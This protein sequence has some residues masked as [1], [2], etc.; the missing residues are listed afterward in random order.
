MANQKNTGKAYVKQG[1]E[2]G[3]KV[4]QAELAA[5]EEIENKMPLTGKN[6]IFML[7]GL[8]LI[9][10]GFILMS[11]GGSSDP[12]VFDYE[13]FSF[14]RITLATIVVLAGFG[15]EIFAIMKRFKK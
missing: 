6:Y 12:D 11:G 13:M 9:A 1:P 4:S 14:R 8:G 15:L 10:L 2:S 3:R 5:Q 7:I